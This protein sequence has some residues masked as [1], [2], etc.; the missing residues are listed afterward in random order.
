MWTSESEVSPFLAV[1]DACEYF[2]S[3]SFYSVGGRKLYAEVGIYHLIAVLRKYLSAS[4]RSSREAMSF[5][6]SR[7]RLWY[8][9]NAGP[10]RFL[11]LEELVYQ[12]SRKYMTCA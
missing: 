4:D 6:I 8:D 3:N 10:E 5:I 7:E 1:T 11:L 2:L 9:D 12:L